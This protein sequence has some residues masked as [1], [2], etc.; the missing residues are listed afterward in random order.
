MKMRR[1]KGGRVELDERRWSRLLSSLHDLD[2][3]FRR[4]KR[5]RA[6]EVGSIHGRTDRLKAIEHL[7]PWVTIG[8]AQSGTNQRNARLHTLEK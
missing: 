1:L 6:I 5:H 7:K 4:A 8:I 3:G 2:A